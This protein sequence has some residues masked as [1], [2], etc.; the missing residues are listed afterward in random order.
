M[1]SSVLNNPLTLDD[2]VD[3]ALQLDSPPPPES[4]AQDVYI[5]DDVVHFLET[6]MYLAGATTALTLHPRQ[7]AVLREMFRRDERGFVYDFML[8]SSI[9]KSAK[10]TIGG[11]AAKWHSFRRP[12]GE[13]YIVGNDLKQADS[14]MA[15]AIRESMRANPK[16]RHIKLS[17]STYKIKLPNGCRIESLPVDPTG[18]AGM[19][20]DAIFWT[21]AWGA[22]EKK[23]EL[24]WTEASLSPTKQYESFIFM[25]SYA[26]HTG[27][28]LILERQYERIVKQ[29]DV[30]ELI[31]ETGAVVP[32]VYV[33]GRSIA[34]WNTEP[35]LSWQ[36]PNYYDNQETR[37][38]PAEFRRIHK[39]EW[40]TSTSAFV[41]AIWW[42][43]CK[44][45]LPVIDARTP[46][47][48]AVDAG[49]SS[50]CFAI[51]AVTRHDKRYAYRAV[52]VFEPPKGGKLDFTGVGSPDEYLRNYVSSNNVLE[53]VFDPY[54]LHSLMTEYRQ[55][56]V[57]RTYEFN[58]GTDR[59][60]ADKA[61]RD[62]IMDRSVM[63]DGDVILRANVLNANAKTEGNDSKLRLVKRSD[64]LKIDAAVCAS[65]CL[66]RARQVRF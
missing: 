28:S 36:T 43:N 4:D 41:D 24:M 5:G 26:G 50:D 53:L 61:F 66:Y 11:G 27:E 42:D 23:H 31:D 57:V 35:Y 40:V 3:D 25:E 6:E 22:K 56:R 38:L 65:M 44:E 16:T 10:T 39:N 1:Q 2:I 21:E 62:G 34:Y 18:E 14:R 12:H 51:L 8:Y 47:I 15:E 64:S 54:Q 63:H 52:K 13:V 30:L 20:P 45:V 9:K 48:L 7:R 37:L 55:Q 17:E 32:G 29:G 60:L 49:V 58:Q 59:L 33:N 46:Q 19:N